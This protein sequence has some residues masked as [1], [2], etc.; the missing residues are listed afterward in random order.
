MVRFVAIA[1][2]AAGV[3]IGASYRMPDTSSARWMA[4]LSVA[5]GAIARVSG[6]FGNVLADALYIRF[7]TYWGHQ[8]TNGRHFMNLEPLLVRILELDPDFKAAYT[9]AAFALAD[10][11]QVEGA[12][13]LLERGM[14]H[15]PRDPFFPY[16]AGMVVFFNTDDYMRAARYFERAAALPDA[17]SDAR[18]MAINMYRRSGRRDLQV[19]GWIDLFRSSR[20]RSVQEVA[21]RGLE[22]LGVR[23]A[24]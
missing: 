1:V 2:L 7:S 20:D 22:R 9:L 15:A 21:R 4:Q 23:I 11:G 24:E 17:M 6:G 12:L 18:F 10:A 19:Q 16:R 5:P 8:L 13:R 14:A 3:A